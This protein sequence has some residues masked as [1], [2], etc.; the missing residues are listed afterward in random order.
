MGSMALVEIFRGRIQLFQTKDVYAIEWDLKSADYER[1]PAPKGINE[2][3][4]NFGL[5]DAN[6]Y[7]NLKDSS[8]AINFFMQEAGI[9]LDGIA[10]INQNSLIHLL[11]AVGSVYFP[12]LETEI[13]A[14]NFSRVMSLMVE[15]KNFQEGTL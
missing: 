12:E 2:L 10:Y 7:A 8:N 13:N 9:E 11:E 15:S 3:T 5:R 14:E 6:Y 1:L 4:E